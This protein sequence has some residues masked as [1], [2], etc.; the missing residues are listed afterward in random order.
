[1]N[2]F[3]SWATGTAMKG[4]LSVKGR[5]IVI[6]GSQQQVAKEASSGQAKNNI[7]DARS[8]LMTPLEEVKCL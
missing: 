6:E 5:I 7:S 4:S 2:T 1:M 8:T 3:L